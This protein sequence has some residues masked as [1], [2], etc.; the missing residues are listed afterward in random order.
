MKA[1]LKSVHLVVT[2]D[3][4]KTVEDFVQSVV[5][6]SNKSGIVVHFDTTEKYVEIYV[7]HFGSEKLITIVPSDPV[8]GG[9]MDIDD[10]DYYN[11]KIQIKMDDISCA[12]VVTALKHEYF[13]NLIPID[14]LCD[15]NAIQ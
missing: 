5:V 6:G 1:E 13:V 14:N 12:E 3:K 4:T 2:N 15:Y 9:W 7:I 10:P 8:H 11:L